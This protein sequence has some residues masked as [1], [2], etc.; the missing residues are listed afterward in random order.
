ML[1]AKP[2]DDD[3]EPEDQD[4]KHDIP[5]PPAALSF[6][7]GVHPAEGTGEYASRLRERIVLLGL[8]SSANSGRRRRTTDHLCELYR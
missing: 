3:E 4:E 6:C 8:V 5:Q 2:P 7:H 1:P